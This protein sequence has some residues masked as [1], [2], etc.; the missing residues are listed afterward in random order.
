MKVL[1]PRQRRTVRPAA[2]HNYGR[3]AAST[4][5]YVVDASLDDTF[6]YTAAGTLEESYN[7]GAGNNAPKGVAADV[8]GNTIWV[9]DNDDYVYV[10]GTDGNLLRSWKASGLSRPEGDRQR[11]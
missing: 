11:W 7:L 8:A 9:I 10:Y 3:P 4:K 1:A 2:I 5:F 6:E